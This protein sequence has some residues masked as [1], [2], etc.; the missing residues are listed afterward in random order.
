MKKVF[1]T[2]GTKFGRLRTTRWETSKRLGRREIMCVCQCGKTKLVRPNNLTSGRVKSCG[3]LPIEQGKNFR[4]HGMT[5]THTYKIWAGILQRCNNPNATRYERYGGRGI[6][7][8][9]EWSSFE[10][11]LSD[12]GKCPS[13]NHSINRIDNNGDY[14]KDNCEWVLNSEQYV[15]KENTIV[16]DDSGVKTSLLAYCKNHNLNYGTIY[17]RVGAGWSVEDAISKPIRHKR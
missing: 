12:M 16:V 7:V 14:T 17:G 6:K 2:P 3:C 11:F 8:C 13:S 4:T 15:N 1:I 10:V 5:G 9:V